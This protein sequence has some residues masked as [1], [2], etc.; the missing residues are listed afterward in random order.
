MCEEYTYVDILMKKVKLWTEMELQCKYSEHSVLFIHS[1]LVGML[2]SP[3]KTL[4]KLN[5]VMI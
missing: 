2:P 5:G 4:V 3:D 1:V